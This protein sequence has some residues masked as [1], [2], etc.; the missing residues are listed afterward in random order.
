[1]L[2]SLADIRK[3]DTVTSIVFGY[4]KV[5]RR[6]NILDVVDVETVS[7]AIPVSG[8]CNDP[9][10][11]CSLLSFERDMASGWMFLP[12]LWR[13]C[14]RRT[15]MWPELFMRPN[16][17]CWTLQ[18]QRVTFARNASRLKRSLLQRSRPG[19]GLLGE[20]RI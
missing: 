14:G 20:L 4:F 12:R 15:Y 18:A 3:L 10:N 16:T 19:R 5:G 1:M 13:F 11:V 7:L 2:S 6:N 8:Q 17:F 9:K